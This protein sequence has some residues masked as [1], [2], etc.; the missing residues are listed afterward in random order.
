MPMGKQSGVL[1]SL[2]S[3]G[4]GVDASFEVVDTALFRVVCALQ[5]GDLSGHLKCLKYANQ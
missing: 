2:H 3:R 4:E 1:H 5:I